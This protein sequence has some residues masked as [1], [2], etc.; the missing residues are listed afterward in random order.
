MGS[1][2]QGFQRSTRC[3]Q[4][5]HSLPSTPPVD[6]VTLS[7]LSLR[8]FKSVFPASLYSAHRAFEI[9]LALETSSKDY[10]PRFLVCSSGIFHPL[11]SPPEASTNFKTQDTR[12]STVCSATVPRQNR[13]RRRLRILSLRGPIYLLGYSPGKSAAASR[14]FPR[15]RVRL[16]PFLPSQTK[17]VLQTHSKW[18]GLFFRWASRSWEPT[19]SSPTT[20][21]RAR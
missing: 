4:S 15:C 20:R 9:W 19:Q 10:H 3:P 13:R 21:P 14:S 18:S 6:P 8:D 5:S 16:L 17:R 11:G 2:R 7:F 1:Y 12:S